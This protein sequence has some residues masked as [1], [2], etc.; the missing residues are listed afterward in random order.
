M[1]LVTEEF[2]A[3]S[4][5][6]SF[7]PHLGVEFEDRGL[8]RE[9]RK[10]VGREEAQNKESS[11]VSQGWDMVVYHFTVYPA[12]LKYLSIFGSHS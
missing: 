4:A 5:N 3:S 8:G 6:M 2:Q 1:A 10:W 7:F 9:E 11:K 12:D